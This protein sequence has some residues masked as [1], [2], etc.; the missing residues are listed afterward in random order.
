MHL[1][2]EKVTVRPDWIYKQDPAVCYLED[3][4]RKHKIIE[5]HEGRGWEKCSRS[6]EIIARQQRGSYALLDEI[7][8]K[9]ESIS[10]DK[11][12]HC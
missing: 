6:T 8:F 10:R 5:Q 12:Y 1:V 11:E 7:E 9:A 4:H 3:T 2:L